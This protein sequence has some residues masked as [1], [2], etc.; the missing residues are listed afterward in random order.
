MTFRR[1]GC[2]LVAIFGLAAPGAVAQSKDAPAPD[3]TWTIRKIIAPAPGEQACYRRVYNSRHLRRHP[4]QQTTEMVLYLRVLGNQGKD[5]SGSAYL[6]TIQTAWTLYVR[7]RHG[8]KLLYAAGDCHDQQGEAVC[9]VD[10]DGGRILVAKPQ[11][12]DGLIVR[13][14]N[15]RFEGCEGAGIHLRPGGEDREFQLEAAPI[16]FC[17]WLEKKQFRD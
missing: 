12:G 5:A 16:E 11:S 9:V 7:L 17:R 1:A 14:D 4:R 3:L 15:V 2:V 6:A 13:Q 10:C 8:E